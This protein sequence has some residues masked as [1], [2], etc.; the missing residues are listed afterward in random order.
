MEFRRSGQRDERRRRVLIEDVKNERSVEEAGPKVTSKRGNSKSVATYAEGA[1]ADRQPRMTDLIPTRLWTLLV[2]GLLGATAIA[3]LQSLY[4]VVYLQLGRSLAEGA[5]G[6]DLRSPHSLA[7]W[8]SAL[9]FALAAAY[10]VLIF[11]LRRHRVDDYRGRYRIW[12]PTAVIMVLASM[13]MIAGLRHAL[14]IWMDRQINV[15]LPRQPE[16][17]SVIFVLTL[18]GLLLARLLVEMRRSRLATVCGVT[19][20]ILYGG[21]ATMWS[22]AVELPAELD[23]MAE[24]GLLLGGHYLVL[25][26]L[27][28][29]ARHVFLDAQ[30]R[31][32]PRKSERRSWFSWRSGD[33]GDVSP[34]PSTTT[35]RTRQTKSKTIRVDSSHDETPSDGKRAARAS[36]SKSGVAKGAT[37]TATKVARPATT[38]AASASTAGAT[39]PSGEGSLDGPGDPVKAAESAKSSRSASSVADAGNEGGASLPDIYVDPETGAERKLSKAERRKL[40]KETRRHQRI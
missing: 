23:V 34:P 21:A 7:R 13:E 14:A 1:K 2:L 5:E 16:V 32:A 3:G 11:L 37:A 31:I 18:S 27:Q 24:Q 25:F 10:S 8:F 17:W 40:R 33:D 30:G 15:S 28:V 26:T 9:I 29:Y 38:K 12:I 35:S 39:R 19:L 22:G 6:L 4:V 20:A 36:S